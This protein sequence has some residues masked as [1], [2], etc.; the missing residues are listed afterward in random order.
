MFFKLNPIPSIGCE[1]DVVV[2]SSF[3]TH[4]DLWWVHFDIWQN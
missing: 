2:V 1:I 4:V 3:R